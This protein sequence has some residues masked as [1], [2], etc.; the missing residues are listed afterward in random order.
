MS[1]QSAKNLCKALLQIRLCQHEVDV[2]RR[3]G[4]PMEPETLHR[5]QQEID[6]ACLETEVDPRSAEGWE[7]WRLEMSWDDETE[8][9]AAEELI[10]DR[11]RNL[12][13]IGWGP[14]S[15]EAAQ[16]DMAEAFQEMGIFNREEDP[17]N[18]STPRFLHRMGYRWTA[19]NCLLWLTPSK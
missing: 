9:A 11:A 7:Q 6:E 16:V 12:V 2:A 19:E 3:N 8:R 10:A 1:W 14:I 15:V 17:E 13:E 4:H 18:Y 5:Q